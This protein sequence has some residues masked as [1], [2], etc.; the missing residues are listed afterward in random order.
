MKRACFLFPFIVACGSP[1]PHP[2]LTD[3]K[4]DTTPAPDAFSCQLPAML[5]SLGVTFSMPVAAQA[6]TNMAP[7]PTGKHWVIAVAIQIVDMNGQPLNPTQGVVMFMEDQVG[8]FATAGAAGPFTK[9]PKT[10]MPITMDDDTTG[11][12]NFDG[13]TGFSG[14]GNPFMTAKQ[15]YQIDMAETNTTTNSFTFTSWP[16]PAAAGGMTK[17]EGSFNNVKLHGFDVD[18]S[19][20]GTANGCT[21]TLTK[22]TFT[23]MNVT[24]PTLALVGS[25]PVDPKSPHGVD[26]SKVPVVNAVLEQ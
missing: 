18:A 22:F 2:I 10:N 20:N 19:G 6:I 16:A 26:F 12:A 17:V 5:G 4:L 9:P 25:D 1:T 13:L 23:N 3:S 21:S 14:T 8:A 24:W 15:I 11:G 7:L